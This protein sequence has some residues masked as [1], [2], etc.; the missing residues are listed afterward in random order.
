MATGLEKK[1]KPKKVR[2]K[3]NPMQKV[4]VPEPKLPKDFNLNTASQNRVKTGFR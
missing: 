1:R 2:G 3:V 4:A